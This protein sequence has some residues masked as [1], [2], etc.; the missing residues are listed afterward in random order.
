MMIKVHNI[1]R[2]MLFKYHKIL[3]NILRSWATIGISRKTVC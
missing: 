2:C 1:Q 3:G